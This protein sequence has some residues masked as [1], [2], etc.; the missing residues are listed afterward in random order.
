MIY[1]LTLSKWWMELRQALPAHS[2]GG[3]GIFLNFRAILTLPLPLP[4]KGGE[5]LRMKEAKQVNCY[6]I[7]QKNI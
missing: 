2:R 7:A 6:I 5:R 4:Y 3:V 1:Y